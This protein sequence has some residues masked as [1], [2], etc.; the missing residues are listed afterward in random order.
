MNK[1]RSWYSIENRADGREA[2]L[3]IYDT[4][5]DWGVSANEFVKDLAGIKANKIIRYVK[6]RTF[7]EEWY[8][9]NGLGGKLHKK[10]M[11]EE[12]EEMKV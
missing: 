12:L 10:R 6:S 4:I 11:E 5:G 2:D 7:V 8:A 9:P 1:S 3:F